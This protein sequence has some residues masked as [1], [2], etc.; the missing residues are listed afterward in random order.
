[1]TNVINTEIQKFI[2]Y[3]VE[4]ISPIY[5]SACLS[6]FV[7]TNSGKEED[8]KVAA[9]TQLERETIYSDKKDFQKIVDFGKMEIEDPLL[10]RQI[11][12]LFLSYQ[13]NQ[14]DEKKLEKIV[15]S[16]SEI[17]NKFATFK[18]EIEGKQYTDNQIE[19]ILSTSTD[20]EEVKK[21]WLASKRIG[22]IVAQDVI[23]IVKI[24]N[25]VAREL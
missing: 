4:K 2:N 23:Q 17:E 22:N 21:A 7:A 9:K 20:N 14:V 18:A 12:I 10:K 1:M 25:E 8:Y 24:R 11:E 6:Y 13:A 5:T 3:H 16:E 15:N 19:H